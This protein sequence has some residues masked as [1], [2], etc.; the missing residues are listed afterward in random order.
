M[1]IELKKERVRLAKRNEYNERQKRIA[2][3]Q[4]DRGCE[5]KKTEVNRRSKIKK[6]N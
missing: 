1:K 5:S 3:E 2:E 4:K 6:N